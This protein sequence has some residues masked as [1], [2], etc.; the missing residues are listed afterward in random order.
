MEPIGVID[1]AFSWAFYYLSKDI[2]FNEAI[3]D[4]LLRG[5]DTDTNAAIVGGLIGA[6]VGIDGINKD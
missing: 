2:S 4:I 6:A 5:G 1:I 3:R